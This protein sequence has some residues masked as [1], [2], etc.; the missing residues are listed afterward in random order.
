MPHMAQVTKRRQDELTV[1]RPPAEYPMF[2]SPF[3]WKV[4][5]AASLRRPAQDGAITGTTECPISKEAL[6]NWL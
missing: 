5:H 2:T 6:K 3:V 1:I 4:R